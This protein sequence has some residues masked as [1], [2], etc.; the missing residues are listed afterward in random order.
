MQNTPE[1]TTPFRCGYVAIIGEPNVGKSTFMNAVLG[2]KL[3]IVTP[4]PQ[5]TRRRILG[6]QTGDGYQIVFVDTPG[7]IKPRYVLQRSM[8][9][10]AHG[11]IAESD[12]VLLMLD[13]DRTLDRATLLPPGLDALLAG[14]GRPVIA[15]LNKTDL[16]RDKKRL[17]PLMAALSAYPFV[18]TVI[19]VSALKREAL[20]AVERELVALLPEHPPLYDVEALSDQPERFFVTEIIREKIFELLR[21]EVPYSTEVVIASYEEL[22][23]HDSI[24]AD[25]IV[26]RD[27]QRGILLGKGG[28]MIKEI[29]TRARKDI[30][31][32]LLR[33][34]YLELHL[35]VREGWRDSED[36]VR[37]FGYM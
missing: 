1:S 25:I 31:E 23:T 30:E 22:E 26:E 20:D 5:T 21:E 33:R 3:S 7:I 9:E 15:V 6:F 28:A 37:R 11:A 24:S 18:H 13:S 17:L 19:P 4:K 14:A 35:K 29:G 12:I 8:V 34:V 16:V 10:A 2:T 27:S 32:F 36:W